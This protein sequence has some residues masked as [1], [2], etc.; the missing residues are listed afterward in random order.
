MQLLSG[1][2]MLLFVRSSEK[3]EGLWS[4]LNMIGAY[5]DSILGRPPAEWDGTAY[6][7]GVAKGKRQ[8]IL[9][10]AAER[11][12]T[13]LGHMQV[14]LEM[15]YTKRGEQARWT[16]IAVI[17][18]VKAVCKW[19]ILSHSRSSGIDMLVPM[20]PEDHQRRYAAREADK[21]MAE[22]RAADQDREAKLEGASGHP[23]L[24]VVEMYAKHGRVKLAHG[25]FAPKFKQRQ[26][27]A[28][29]LGRVLRWVAELLYI[30]RPMVYVMGK[31][32]L[33]RGNSWLPLL[34]SLGT[35]VLS[36]VCWMISSFTQ[37]LAPEQNVELR[38][39]TN[40]WFYYLLLNPAFSKLTV[41]PIIALRRLLTKVPIIGGMLIYVIDIVLSL[42][43]YHFYT[44]PPS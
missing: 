22:V 28:K 6:K 24:D 4:A 16:A 15:V 43:Q 14:L 19:V 17:E 34:L 23:H 9:L 2:R 3:T 20:Y 25:D 10:R 7:T 26:D 35:D 37:R 21:F 30:A 5:H 12:A 36:R 38:R 31:L 13:G 39:R 8:H 44:A 27:S 18:G 41:H 40:L 42:Q 1:A 32:K 33:R 11:V 29:G